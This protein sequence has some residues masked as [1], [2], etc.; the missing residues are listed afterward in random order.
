MIVEIHRI[1][2]GSWHNLPPDKNISQPLVFNPAIDGSTRQYRI[3]MSPDEL[4][5]IAARTGYDLSLAVI[6]GQTHPF[7]DSPMMRIKLDRSTVNVWEVVSDVDKLRLAVLKGSG[8]VAPTEQALLNG[9]YPNA[10]FYIYSEEEQIQ[11]DEDKAS[12]QIRAVTM[13]NEMTDASAHH[14]L[15]LLST[16]KFTKRS[17]EFV[18]TALMGKIMEDVNSFLTYAAM[19]PERLRT[20]VLIEEAV[21]DGKLQKEGTSYFYGSDRLGFTRE[22]T[23]NFL[24]QNVN[25]P[26]YQRLLELVGQK[27]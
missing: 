7:W 6:P 27:L 3:E 26:I 25:Q 23:A 14:L 8:L 24:E 1:N 5:E 9:D 15:K 22:E 17:A 19:T 2:R 18:R 20:Y 16:K 13:L 4:K 11:R 10:E 12:R 21:M